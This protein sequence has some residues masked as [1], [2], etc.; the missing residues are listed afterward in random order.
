[1]AI[2][3]NL[4]VF[5]ETY[6]LL[7]MFIRQGI[8]LQRESRYT[9]GQEVKKELMGL[10]IDIYEANAATEKEDFIAEARKKIVAIKLNLRLLHDTQ[11]ISTK[12][13]AIFVD[14]IETVSKQ[15]AAWINYIRRNSK[16]GE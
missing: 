1:M 9:I 5:K 11:Q 2:Y 3:D 10:C 12:Q 15:L 14:K 7:L 6:D 16:K 4:P 8:H 13:F